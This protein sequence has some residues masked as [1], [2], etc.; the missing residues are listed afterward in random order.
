[1]TA[2]NGSLFY[3]EIFPWDKNFETG[4]A[5]IDEQHQEL[6]R[7]LNQL[8]A[9]LAN[10]AS[11]VKLNDIFAELAAYADYH[12]KTEESIWSA[13]LTG[14]DW[15]ITHKK[16]H[17]SFIDKVVE[18]KQLERDRPL[19][20]VV[21]EIVAFLTQWLAY[22]ILDSD[23]RM[24]MAL[25]AIQ[26]GS[27]VERAKHL[28][29]EEMGGSMRILIETVLKMYSNLSNRTMELMRESSLRRQA[30]QLAAK[31]AADLEDATHY[32]RTLFNASPVGLVLS[33]CD[34]A[35]VD[36]NPAFLEI[37]GYARDEAMMLNYWKLIT[38]ENGDEEQRYCETLKQ[39]G[40]LGPI[41]KEYLHR[42]GKHVAVR[43]SSL[44][45]EQKGAR[46]VFSAVEN[47]SRHKASEAQLAESEN[48]FRGLFESSS[49]AIMLLD[50]NGFFECNQATLQMFDCPDMSTF[51]T[52]HPGDLSPPR[53]PDGSPS[54]Q[55]A[56]AHIEK[57]MRLGTEF[58]EWV[59]WRN[60]DHREFFAEVL[61]NTMQ[62]GGRTVLQAVVR[63]ISRRKQTED[64]LRASEERFR[65]LFREAP[66]PLCYVDKNGVLVDINR[67][68]EQTFGYKL[69]DVPRLEDW[70]LRA[71]PDA[72]YRAWVLK[73]WNEA[74]A[75]AV[76]THNDITGI[77][78][79]VTCKNGSVR[80]MIIS[81]IVWGDDF[82]ATFFDITPRK[83]AEAALIESEARFRSFFE[84]NQSVMLLIQPDDGRIIAAN[85]AAAK[86][87]G[88]PKERLAAL[89]IQEINTLP[90]EA[91]EVERHAAEHSERNY[92]NFKHR[93]ASGKIRDVEVYSTPIQMAQE[94]LLF[95]IVHD[96]TDRKE[97]ELRNAQFAAII[98]ES[99]DFIGIAAPSGQLIYINKATADALKLPSETDITNLRVMDILSPESIRKAREIT[100]PALAKNG[101]WK[102]EFQL[103]CQDGEEIPVSHVSMLHRNEQG[104][105]MFMSTIMRDIRQERA[106]QQALRQA[107]D[108]AETAAVAKS[109]F[110]TN[111]S[112]EIRTPLNAITGMA[113][114]IRR[115]GLT[116]VQS[117][118]MDKLE[119]AGTHLLGIINAILELSK[120]EAGKF[121][122]EEVPLSLESL[123]GNV[124]SILRERAD[125]KQLALCTQ[126]APM[127]TGLLGD[128]TRIQQAMLNYATNAIKFTDKG[129]IT[130][131]VTL[132][133]DTP[134]NALIRFE[135][136]DTGI[137]IAPEIMPRLFSAFEQ[138]D[139]STT[140]KY[141]GTG[142]GLAITMK[143]AE[144]MGG[145]AGAE[146]TPGMGSTFW[147][148]IRLKKT[149]D[150]SIAPA[151][152]IQGIA[153]DILKR[154]FQGTRILLAEDEPINQ[155]ITQAILDD[156]GLVVE[157]ANNGVE[158]LRKAGEQRYAMILM[159]MQMPEMDGLEAT[160][161]IRKLPD[162][163]KTPI[164]AMT[165][166]A[167]A[168]DKARCME[169][170]MNDFIAKPVAPQ[171]LY[172][173]ILNWLQKK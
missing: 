31:R 6:V 136:Q 89:S 46:Y 39:T 52:L 9:H 64:A 34:G 77:E 28:A 109:A 51:A 141:G 171:L 173:T 165:A 70:W 126:V 7:I 36:V 132:L 44:L 150:N 80:T 110:L 114:L 92:F 13:H 139:T 122:L 66:I 163:A 47:L 148:T 100:L 38:P 170:G 97:L 54:K 65:R 42:Q 68:F 99:T 159:D 113:H 128:P 10:M 33:T 137:G 158:A 35:L 91:I 142:L 74:M 93:L 130:L 134:E 11:P 3:F 41:E 78:Y 133:D 162:C 8:A 117:E 116:P 76:R 61:L 103:R 29:N 88:Y 16:T 138:A 101:Y 156:V 83:Q 87:Y 75:K 96:V 24:A 94:R 164:L 60:S 85:D 20:D 57:A 71:Y 125:S 111:M 5:K 2:E 107:K 84:A 104:T 167:F 69:D 81:G 147:F 67:R 120:I 50:E 115:T 27:D 145:S 149:S 98:D 19:Y 72:D 48:R 151:T 166:N 59:H 53:Q 25:Q 14:D 112:H 95:S 108:E 73:T 144:L 23:K 168:E 155:E 160:R 62:L 119:A 121:T 37:I 45:I 58:F 146:S 106:V 124:T 40:T 172:S 127:P 15:F 123:V 82:L 152:T 102:G 118:Q 161:R 4:I 157:T 1:M 131:R 26:S 49:D 32:N 143:I 43:V 17:K 135:T 105:P 21:Q 12:F 22:H 18:L 56:M 90:A 79:Q 30:E 154:N 86:Y 140:R 129:S 63:D 153:E 55:A 169:A